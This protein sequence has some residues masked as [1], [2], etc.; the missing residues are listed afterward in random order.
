MH[1]AICPLPQYAFMAWCSVKKRAQGGHV[2]N[3]CC[4]WEPGLYLVKGTGH[5]ELWWC[6]SSLED[7]PCGLTIQDVPHVSKDSVPVTV[8]LLFSMEGIQLLVAETNK[9]YS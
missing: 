5:M 1:G 6:P 7:P 2:K 8:F 3:C 9:H 4:K